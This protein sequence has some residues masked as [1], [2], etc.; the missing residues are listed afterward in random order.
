[1]KKI[2]LIT[3]L[4]ALAACDSEASEPA[5]VA[6]PVPVAAPTPTL[7][8]PNEAVFA[9][10]FAKACPSAEPVSTSLCRSKGF[11][12]QGFVCE[13]GLG[14]D[15]YRRNKADLTAGDGEW[16]IDAEAAC[17]AK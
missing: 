5:P 7:P 1:M 14:D 9:E 6:T 17:A 3:A 16:I 12:Q 15:E 10:A 4:L 8:A 2:V 11:G 13:F